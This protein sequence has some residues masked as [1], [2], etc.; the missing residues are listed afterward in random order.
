MSGVA[1]A[2]TFLAVGMSA[3]GESQHRLHQQS[4]RNSPYFSSAIYRGA[5]YFSAEATPS[6][7]SGMRASTF[8]RPRAL[9]IIRYRSHVTNIHERRKVSLFVMGLSSAYKALAPQ[10]NLRMRSLSVAAPTGSILIVKRFLLAGVNF[11][12]GSLA[13]PRQLPLG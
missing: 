13:A 8:A 12:T 2:S 11:G 6:S 9:S 10:P 1:T 7:M 4:N 5:F 3:R